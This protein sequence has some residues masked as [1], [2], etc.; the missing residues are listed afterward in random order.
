MLL[1]KY[2]LLYMS[3][4][5]IRLDDYTNYNNNKFLNYEIFI[6]TGL[7]PETLRPSGKINFKPT[8]E[9]FYHKICLSNDKK[10]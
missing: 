2:K 7:Y 8:S 6:L 3:N 4:K 5:I 10:N 1:I 9:T